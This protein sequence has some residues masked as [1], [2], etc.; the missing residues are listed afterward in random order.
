M[1]Y[2]SHKTKVQIIL[3]KKTQAV[4]LDQRN[5]PGGVTSYKAEHEDNVLH[6]YSR[7]SFLITEKT[8]TSMQILRDASLVP[9]PEDTI[10]R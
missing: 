9:N 4:F 10:N 7:S 1:F 2:I 3:N 6:T 5:L 8:K